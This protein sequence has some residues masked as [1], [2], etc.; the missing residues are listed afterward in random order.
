MEWNILSGSMD[1]FNRKP[2]R[3]DKRE[4]LRVDKKGWISY[5]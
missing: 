3:K 4:A 2:T 5:T 1:I